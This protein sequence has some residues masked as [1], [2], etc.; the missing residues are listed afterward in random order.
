MAEHASQVAIAPSILNSDL[1]RLA[2]SLRLLEEADVDWVHLDVMD[3]QFVPNL[4]IGV[5]VVASVRAATRLP[6]DVHLMI[7]EPERFI[8]QFVEAGADSITVHYEATPHQ[9]RALQT[10]RSLGARASLAINIGTPIAA[11][12]DLLPACD[13]V[14]VMSI[15]PGFGGQAFVPVTLRRLRELRRALDAEGYSHDVQVDGGVS[16]RNARQIVEAGSTN[17]VAGSAIFGHDGGVVAAVNEL[18]AAVS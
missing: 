16:A 15:N 14:L 4:S 1:A 7:V 8:P 12:L 3:G 11:I 6:L 13:K 9:H 5:P 17:L 18:R 10:I 2:D